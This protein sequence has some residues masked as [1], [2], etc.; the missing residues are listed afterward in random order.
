MEKFRIESDSIGEKQ[1]PIDAY[2]GVQT[3][4]AKENFQ[5]SGKRVH[6][7]FVN[8][9]VE[10]KKASAIANKNSGALKEDVANTM[11][12]IMYYYTIREAIAMSNNTKQRLKYLEGTVSEVIEE[13][14]IFTVWVEIP[15]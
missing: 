1:I 6:L 5:I 8:S 11:A 12:G 15:E 7:E 14:G 3:L 13:E 9:I 2:Y 4:R 10:T